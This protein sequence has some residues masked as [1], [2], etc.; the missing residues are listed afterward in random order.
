MLSNADRICGQGEMVR[1]LQAGRAR[2]SEYMMEMG[3]PR[4]REGYAA[5]DLL[6]H[7][8][9]LSA[10]GAGSAVRIGHIESSVTAPWSVVIAGAQRG[11]G[12]VPVVEH[13][14]VVERGV[15]VVRVW[16]RDAHAPLLQASCGRDRGEALQVAVRVKDLMPIVDDLARPVPRRHPQ[17][18]PSVAFEEFAEARA[19]TLEPLE[20]DRTRGLVAPLL[21]RPPPRK[22]QHVQA[23]VR[24]IPSPREIEQQ[25]HVPAR[26]RQHEPLRTGRRLALPDVR[27]QDLRVVLVDRAAT[28][29]DTGLRVTN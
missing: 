5:R 29:V 26:K 14:V 19:E 2:L 15:V 18:V 25:V 13:G 20:H 23:P 10:D 17:L 3:V 1:T 7:V 16:R 24:P 11:V 22:R 9:D 6:P 4:L 21:C 12:P 28:E 27:V 8:V